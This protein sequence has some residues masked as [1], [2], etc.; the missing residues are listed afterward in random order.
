MEY[1][2]LAIVKLSNGTQSGEA[3]AQ[4]D[5]LTGAPDSEGFNYVVYLLGGADTARLG[6]AALSVYTVFT[7]A[8]NDTVT[9]GRGFFHDGPGNDLY[10]IKGDAT[11]YAGSGNDTLDGG[12]PDDFPFGPDTVSF[13]F[14]PD[15]DVPFNRYTKNLIVDL[16]DDGPQSFGDFGSDTLLNIEN[17]TTGWGHDAIDGNQA[18]NALRGLKG[19]DTIH[20]HGGD[21]KLT[22]DTDSDRLYGEAG[23]D[24]LEGSDGNDILSG[25]SGADRLQGSEGRDVITGG[26]GGDLI[27]L[28]EFKPLR[29]TIKYTGVSD[30]GIYKAGAAQTWDVIENFKQMISV[31]DPIG[32]KIDLRAL[33]PN[34]EASGNPALAWRGAKGF[35]GDANWQVRLDTRSVKGSTVVQIDADRDTNPEMSILIKGVTGMHEYDFLL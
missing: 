23:E 27:V 5:L 32:D 20:G 9:G 7:G 34:G 26:T 19:R 16:R 24:T 8:G 22:G 35:T 28:R 17:V 2:T 13:E 15:Q 12:D 21:D 18:D 29:D 10:R 14:A 30:S 11:F 3:T 25:G 33:D 1:R 6:N 31:N 4:G